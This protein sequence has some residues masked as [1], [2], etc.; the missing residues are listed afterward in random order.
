MRRNPLAPWVLALTALSLA[1]PGSARPAPPG[2]TWNAWRFLFGEWVAEGG[3]QPGQASGG[4]FSFAPDLD[5]RVLIRRSH[6]EYAATKDRAAFR[7]DD[8]MVVYRDLPGGE[9]RA[10][11]ADNEG[12]VIHYE[13]V[14]D[15]AAGTVVFTSAP[16]PRTPRYRFTYR[17][18]APDSL[19]FSFDVAPPGKPDSLATYV[20]GTARRKR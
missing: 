3:G 8:L 18:L 2:H 15:T 9:I 6:A 4:A 11:Y 20:K 14:V 16:V 7:H 1:V 17:K 5:G 13:A 10:L 12:H 19:A